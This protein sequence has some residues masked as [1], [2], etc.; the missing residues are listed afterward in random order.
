[1]GHPYMQE[2]L[3]SSH[4]LS[5]HAEEEKLKRGKETLELEKEQAATSAKFKVLE[6]NSQCG[7]SDGT[8]SYFEKNNSKE[9][10]KLNPSADSFVTDEMVNTLAVP[11]YMSQPQVVKPK[12]MP[13]TKMEEKSLLKV[14]AP[15]QVMQTVGN[16][17]LA[18]F[19]Q[20][21]AMTDCHVLSGGSWVSWGFCAFPLF[22]FPSSFPPLPAPIYSVWTCGR[23]SSVGSSGKAH[24]QLIPF[25]HPPAT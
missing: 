25:H 23:V 13:A 3:L 10:G 15:I 1:M 5:Y 2:D 20:T 21:Q 17:T 9:A 8:N 14:D 6:I 16:Q 18:G 12:Q 19:P 7:L 24:L 22:V 11:A 4:T